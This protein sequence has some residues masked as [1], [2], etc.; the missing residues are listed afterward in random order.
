MPKEKWP[1]LFVSV[2]VP[3]GAKPFQ[4]LQNARAASADYA[5]DRAGGQALT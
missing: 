5:G 4:R 2:T 1:D 3:K